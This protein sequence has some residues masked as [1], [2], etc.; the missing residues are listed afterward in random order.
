LAQRAAHKAHGT[1]H[2]PRCS[3]HARCCADRDRGQLQAETAR[4]DF[5]LDEIGRAVEGLRGLGLA[6]GQELEEQAP[7]VADLHQR[8]EQAGAGLRAVAASAAKLA[9]QAP[10]RASASTWRRE[11][12]EAAGVVSRAMVATAPLA[13]RYGA[14]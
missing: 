2:N 10:R 9:G 1:R 8:A 13:A 12:E 3:L 7:R 4:Q 11:Q 14:R 5:Y 6:M